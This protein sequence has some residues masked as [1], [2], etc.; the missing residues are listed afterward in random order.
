MV[1]N[2]PLKLVGHFN[3]VQV[4]VFFLI[5]SYLVY[6][7][8]KCLLIIVTLVFLI[9]SWS[10]RACDYTSTR[11]HVSMSDS[12]WLFVVTFTTIGGYRKNFVGSCLNIDFSSQVMEI[13]IHPLIVDEVHF[14]QL[15]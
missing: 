4:D 11:E 10:L 3:H 7:P 8:I 14:L 1:R 2:V 15:F 9:G 5:K 12:M 6:R 13:N